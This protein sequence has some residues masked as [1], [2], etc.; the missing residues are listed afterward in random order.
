MWTPSLV[1]SP[2]TTLRVSQPGSVL[3]E[4]GAHGGEPGLGCQPLSSLIEFPR[5]RQGLQEILEH[6]DPWVPI[7]LLRF[8]WEKVPETLGARLDIR[9]MVYRNRFGAALPAT[10]SVDGLPADT[11]LPRADA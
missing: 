6:P 1:R 8:G 4:H 3:P 7:S 11:V 9:R 10:P 2:M 5:G